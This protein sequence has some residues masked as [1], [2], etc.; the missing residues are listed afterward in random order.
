MTHPHPRSR[1]VPQLRRS[2]AATLAAALLVLTPVAATAV[3]AA[4]SDQDVRDARRAVA[5]AESSVAAIE[6]RLAQQSA[7]RDAALV[8][9][10]QAA[11]AY[12]QAQV[13]A[14]AAAAAATTAA[15]SHRVAQEQ[16]EAARRTLVAIARQS[17]RSGG[18][19]DTVQAFLS[20]D[21]FDQV[22]ERSTALA[23]VSTK[24]DT[25]V[26]EYRAAQLVATTLKNRADAAV[27]A[28]E[29]AAE[30]AQDALAEAKAVQE[31]ADDAV[32]A[33]TVEREGLIAQLAAARSTSAEVERARQDALDVERRAREN[34]AA[35]ARRTATPAPAAGPAAQAPPAPSSAQAPAAQ[36]PAA[37]A[38]AAPAPAAPAP[39]APAPAAP[40]PAPAAPAP[41]PAAPAPAPA[42]PAPAP[43]VPAPAPAPSNPYGLGT[44]R[45][46]G[47]AGQGEAASAWARTQAG[48]PYLWG[49]TGPG[50]YDCSGLTGGA[51]RS[52]GVNLNRTSRDQYKQVLK[53][54]Y[55]SLRP[56][57]LVFWSTD[58]NNPDKIHHVAL[59]VG[60]GQIMEA[61]REGVPVRL[62]SM[63]WSGTMPYAG[64]P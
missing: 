22:V 15:E 3:P 45:S 49:G 46:R 31:E 16:A 47:S 28:Q 38:P 18:S 5:G 19:M 29:E 48:I 55:D 56:G 53:I 2:A 58:P 12:T 20:A 27:A 35:Q 51:W 9:V 6:V 10:Q 4:P 1:T 11:E 7:E 14:E 23:R 62:A 57:D 60:G 54:S 24:A 50:G 13:D 39:A 32:A 43:A 30:A 40:A 25:A 63:R 41:A 36:A 26:Q 59:Y 42:A 21:G 17:A 64:R 34:A 37:P 8:R 61:A 33:A 52:A 44:G